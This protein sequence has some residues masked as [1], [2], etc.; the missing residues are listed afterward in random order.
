MILI[1]CRKCNKETSEIFCSDCGDEILVLYL[2]EKQLDLTI[3]RNLQLR[4]GTVLYWY[5]ICKNSNKIDLEYLEYVKR[6][7]EKQAEKQVKKQVE[8]KN[9]E[10]TKITLNNIRY[11]FQEYLNGN[12]YEFKMFVISQY[13]IIWGLITIC[14][15]IDSA[16]S[17]LLVSIFPYICMLAWVIA[18]FLLYKNKENFAENKDYKTMCYLSIFPPTFAILYVLPI[19]TANLLILFPF[20]PS[21]IIEVITYIFIRLMV[22]FHT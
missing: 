20:N 9:Q 7:S 19:V 15:I 12:L 21:A 4:P 2:I 6:Q 10:S 16:T 17:F 1:N 18:N 11:C 14:Q 22:F 8:E 5:N 13:I 3:E